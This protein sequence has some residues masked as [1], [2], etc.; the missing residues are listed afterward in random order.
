MYD[1]FNASVEAY[2][3]SQSHSDY[4]ITLLCTVAYAAFA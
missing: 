4:N 3:L 2:D 1:V